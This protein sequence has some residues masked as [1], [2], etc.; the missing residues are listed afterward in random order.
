VEITNS[1][2]KKEE[3]VGQVALDIIE[4]EDDIIIIAPIA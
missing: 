3:D 4:T 2:E 1:E